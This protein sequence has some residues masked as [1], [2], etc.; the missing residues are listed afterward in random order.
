MATKLAPDARVTALNNL[1]D[2]T[3]VDGRDAIQREFQFKDF[4]EA[5]AF[6]NK[7]ADVAELVHLVRGR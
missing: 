2:W 4:K 5:W 3:E 6:M 7:V 1:P